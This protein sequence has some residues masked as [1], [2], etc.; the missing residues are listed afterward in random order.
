MSIEST[1]YEILRL[2]ECDLDELTV[3]DDTPAQL[4][5]TSRFSISTLDGYDNVLTIYYNPNS[6]HIREIELKIKDKYEH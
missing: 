6:A 4:R 3:G 2:L 5:C 1:E